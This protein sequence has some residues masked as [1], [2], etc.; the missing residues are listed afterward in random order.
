MPDPLVYPAELIAEFA[1]LKARNLA[2][3][4]AAIAGAADREGLIDHLHR[5][6][7]AAGL[8]GE[9]ALGEAAKALG[10]SIEASASALPA[11]GYAALAGLIRAS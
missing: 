5:L 3:L 9:G 2:L 11:A 6:G 8:F 1:G 4:D 7:G 10:E